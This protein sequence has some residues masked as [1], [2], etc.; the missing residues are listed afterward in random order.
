[1]FC[2]NQCKPNKLGFVMFV[3]D[4]SVYKYHEKSHN[5]SVILCIYVDDVI[6]ISTNKEEIIKLKEN[7]LKYV[8][9]IKDLGEVQKYLGI[10]IEKD[11]KSKTVQLNQMDYIDNF[12]SEY[13]GENKT[14]RTSPLGQVIKYRELPNNEVNPSLLPIM[15]KIRYTAD[16]TRPD[17]LTSC[18]LLASKA[19]CPDD[20]IVNG[21]IRCLQYL[22]STKH[23]K[24][25]LGG[26]DTNFQLFGFVDASM[27][28]SGNGRPQIGIYF[29]YNLTSG[30]FYCV[31]KLSQLI[32][33]SSTHAEIIGIDMFCKINE[34]L[35]LFY[36]E[37]GMP[38]MKPTRCFN[39]SQS[40][41]MR[42]ETLKQ[43]H[44][45]K[46][47]NLRINY[48]REQI[49]ARNI[50]LNYI[51]NEENVADMLMKLLVGTAFLKL[52]RRLLHGFDGNDPDEVLNSKF[53][54]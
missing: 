15:G 26:T 3:S 4:P 36:H 32:S 53:E 52:R 19:T 11:P 30:A 8:K 29:Y 12:V 9:E 23:L 31:S 54:S 5:L 47:I 1:M 38:L 28:M 17:L 34:N 24:L 16:R 45:T 14:V 25:R 44:R 43:T 50:E 22:R 21:T 46:H 48:I 51:R 49:N 20:E 10:K 41:M 18:S 42:M 27:S 13:I 7:L 40:A 37:Y 33:T 35:R 2:Q 6:I 39:D